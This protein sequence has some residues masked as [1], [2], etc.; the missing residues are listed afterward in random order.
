M[1]SDGPLDLRAKGT[2][3]LAVLDPLLAA[4]GR[5]IRGTMGLDAA[6]QGSLRTPRLA[7]S[8]TLREVSLE[9]YVQGVHLSNLSGVLQAD[10]DSLRL[11]GVSGKAGAGAF[12]MEGKV[13]VLVPGL[14]VDVTFVGH[15]IRPLASDVLTADMDADLHVTGAVNDRLSIVGTIGITRA[16]ITIP[17]SL[18][19][20]VGVLKVTRKGLPPQPHEPHESTSTLTLDLKIEAPE[21]VFLR[22]RGVDAELGGRLHIRGSTDDPRI[23]GGFDLRHGTYS[24]AGQTLTVKGGRIGLDS[25]SPSGKLD[26]TLDL[27]SESS[28]NGIVATLA[29]T[30]YADAPVIKLSSTPDLPQDEILARLL[31]NESASQLSPLQ[32]A[33]IA[34]GLASMSGVGGGFDPLAMVRKTLGIDRLSVSSGAATGGNTNTMVDAGKYVASG[35]YVGTRQGLDGGTQARVQIDLTRH[36]KLDSL[37]GTGGGTPA[38]GATI[39]NDPGSSLGLTYQVEY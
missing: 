21:Q 34:Q 19:P 13:G 14:P 12:T 7:G 10:G 28:A 6:I 5:A 25:G 1:R 17:D 29:V 23:E 33:A 16:E 37:I 38:T 36:L 20:T 35:V 27:S 11:S 26:P 9:D 2:L 4:D 18:P 8:A 39:E 3:D 31:F 32:M 30:G 15:G 24:L 22:G